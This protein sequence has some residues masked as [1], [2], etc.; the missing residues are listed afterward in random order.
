MK[1][2][3]RARTAVAVLTV[4]L[5]GSLL[6]IVG[7]P[8]AS[9]TTGGPDGFGYTFIDDLS[10]GGPAFS[11][12]D[13]SA[14]G[15][16]LVSGDDVSA[17]VATPFPVRIYG[18][19]VN[20]LNVSTNGIVS[21][22][23]NATFTNLCQPPGLA[24]GDAVFAHWDDLL[25][26]GVGDGVRTQTFGTAPNQTFVIEWDGGYFSGGGSV[27]FNVT[28]SESDNTIKLRYQTVTQG[29]S[30]A[31]V[32][33]QQNG[34]AGAFLPYSCNT[35]SSIVTPRAIDF[36]NTSVPPPPP[37][38]SPST[39]TVSVIASTPDA[40]EGGADGAFTFTRTGSTAG[41]LTVG[42]S[43]GGTATSGTD[44]D[45]PG[46]VIFPAG[47]SSVIRP[48]H[49]LADG[50]ADDGE[51][52]TA[53]VAD[54]SGYTA[55][56]PRQATVTIHDEGAGTDACTNAPMSTYSDRDAIPV[57]AANIDCITAYTLAQGFTD[58]TYRPASPA[59]RPQMAS[60]VAR[61]LGKAGVSLPT[62]PPDAFPGD[63]AGPPHEL[64]INQL[65]ALGVLDATTGQQGDAYDVGTN[66]RR[67]DM[68]QLLFNAY[69]V[70]A[71]T[72][73]PAGDDA[74]TDDDGNDNEAAI[75]ALAKAGVVEG[76]GGGLYDPSGSVGRG[77]FASFFARFVQV[78]VDGGFMDPL[79]PAP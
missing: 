58:G 6:A 9:A 67:D 48:V 8:P 16:F 20:S 26:T 70:I 36:I 18:S 72:D 59:T 21:T 1:R 46:S 40:T 65:A 47:Q 77:Q 13:I 14:T 51:T 24:N 11:Y 31:T 43:L 62:N 76:T 41:S 57:H 17:V 3:V 75:N 4:A 33:I 5:V 61:L 10:P 68:A 39:T 37:S 74:F 55:G 25:L 60:F 50:V 28:F 22:L 23:A 71:G 38:A 53:V 32:G 78:L 2:S 49:A 34:G 45:P 7:A 27:H 56:S 15:T 73:L 66:M 44:Y 29:G 52:V 54:G 30:S 35:G 42:Y 12:Q 79:P 63:N 19:I 69:A 64:S